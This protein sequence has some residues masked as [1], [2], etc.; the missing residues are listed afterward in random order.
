MSKF[1]KVLIVIAVVLL[2]FNI[3]GFVAG[4][5]GMLLKWALY[6]VLI[7]LGYRLVKKWLS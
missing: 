6:A 5:I 7:Y 2:V 3:F 4:L 1:L